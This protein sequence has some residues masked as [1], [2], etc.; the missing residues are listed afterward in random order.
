MEIKK[1]CCHSL[2]TDTV[3]AN[4]RESSRIARACE[5]IGFCVIVRHG[6]SEELLRDT[7]D[8]TLRFFDLPD[9]EKRATPLN[10]YGAGYSPLQGETLSATMGD[11]APADLKESLNARCAATELRGCRASRQVQTDYGGRTPRH[12]N[13]K[14][15]KT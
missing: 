1:L 11:A 4:L 3:T 12:E 13:A 2:C 5:E 10:Q 6:V 14:A 7:H 15:Y 8:V 9:A